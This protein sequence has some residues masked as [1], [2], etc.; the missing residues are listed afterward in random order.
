[1]TNTLSFDH[2]VLVVS[3]LDAATRDFTNLGFAVQPG[4]K[5]AGGYSHN[6]LIGLAD[7][8]YLELFATVQPRH[9][10]LLRTLQRVD[11]LGLLAADF[12][13]VQQR[14]IRS[15]ARGDGFLDFALV[16]TDLEGDME[17]VRRHDIAMY[18]PLSGARKRPDGE[19]LAWR[20]GLPHTDRM[21][22]LIDDVTPRELRAPAA[23]TDQHPNGAVGVAGVAIAVADLDRSVDRFGALLDAT[24]QEVKDAAHLPDACT[25]HFA[26]TE[27]FTV[28]LA[29]PQ[30]EGELQR[31]LMEFG[32]RP[33][34][35]RLYTNQPE[36]AGL[37]D[38]TL[39]H[40]ARIELIQR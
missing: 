32:E 10:Q 20:F 14:F 36:H 2:A 16:S 7:G 37:L 4:G 19:K 8:G 17:R 28:T 1:M 22:F 29:E 33:Y 34:L 40:G 6:A 5:H 35:L 3:D 15:V 27:R 39:V 30:A 23:T 12:G 18:G 25:V 9:T 24:P 26:V 21:P 11:A 38:S 13:P 31:H